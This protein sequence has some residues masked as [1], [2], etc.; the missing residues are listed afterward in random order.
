MRNPVLHIKLTDLQGIFSQIGISSDLAIKVMEVATTTKKQ[1]KKEYIISTPT[2][3]I[4]KKLDKNK[5]AESDYTENFNR[6]LSAVQQIKQSKNIP[7]IFKDSKNYVLLKEIAKAAHDY[8]SSFKFIPIEEGYKKFCEIAMEIMG[9][10]YKLEKIKYYLPQIYEIT[11]CLILIQADINKKG[12][13]EFYL[14]WKDIALKYSVTPVDL[15]KQEDFLHIIYARDEADNMKAKY[16]DWITSQFEGLSFLSVI[17]ELNQ[18]YGIG[19]KRRYQKYM[20]TKGFKK[21]EEGT[22]RESL[23][24]EDQTYW[25]MVQAGKNKRAEKI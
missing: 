2:S 10:K 12:S 8:A 19:A 20:Q 24:A 14:Q 22:Q 9:K 7:V 18:M 6:I 5:E 1:L 17:P 4:K 15:M 23:T 16:T 21:S 25:E 11:E 3:K 13:Q